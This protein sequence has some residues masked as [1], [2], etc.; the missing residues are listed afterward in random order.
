[1]G[2]ARTRRS[3]SRRPW[4]TGAAN[5]AVMCGDGVTGCHGRAETRDRGRAFDLGFAVRNGVLRAD[6]API[7]HAIF[8]WALLNDDGGW[9]PCEEPDGAAA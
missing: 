8:G 3:E 6:E 2:G 5:G 4:L 7:L 9:V 1:M